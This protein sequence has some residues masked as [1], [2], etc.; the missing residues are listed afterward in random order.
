[1]TMVDNREG[2]GANIVNKE[3]EFNMD[4]VHMT[5]RNIKVYGESDLP[6]CP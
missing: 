2:V 4:R 5:F 3:D 6:D 1:M